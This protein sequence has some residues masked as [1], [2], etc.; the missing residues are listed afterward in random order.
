MSNLEEICN[1]QLLTVYDKSKEIPEK[2][3]RTN[4]THV[5]GEVV[6]DV[7]VDL[8]GTTGSSVDS[9]LPTSPAQISNDYF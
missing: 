1:K 8:S 4:K 2:R 5:Q 6:V 9:A 7:E 3:G